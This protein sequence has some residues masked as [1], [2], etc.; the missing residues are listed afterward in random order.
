[1]TTPIPPIK[2]VTDA[3][4]ALATATAKQ[5]AAKTSL[6]T[7]LAQQAALLRKGDATGAKLLDAKIAA[8]RTTL[9]AATKN[10]ANLNA[11][12]VKASDGLLVATTPESLVATLDARFPITMLPVSSV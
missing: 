3:R 4:A 1:M 2:A 8:A 6:A 5:T 11:Q 10:V 9:D 12:L 7:L